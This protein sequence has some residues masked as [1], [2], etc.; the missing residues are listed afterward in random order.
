MEINE[1]TVDCKWCGTPTLMLGT[2][3]CDRCWELQ[4]RIESNLDL[5]KRMIEELSL[6][7]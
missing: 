1:K 5:A 2:K 3:M 4:T 7:S 6:E